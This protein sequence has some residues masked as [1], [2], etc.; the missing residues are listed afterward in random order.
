M[1]FAHGW[2]TEMFPGPGTV[3]AER[4]GLQGSRAPVI[5]HGLSPSICFLG[6]KS[7]LFFFEKKLLILKNDFLKLLHKIP[8][9]LSFEG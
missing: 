1:L 4:P 7:A 8:F 9:G 6:W 3:E 5:G 2:S